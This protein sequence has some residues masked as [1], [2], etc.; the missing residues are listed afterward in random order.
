VDREVVAVGIEGSLVA[1]WVLENADPLPRAGLS[2][3]Q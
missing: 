3:Y 2:K 1:A